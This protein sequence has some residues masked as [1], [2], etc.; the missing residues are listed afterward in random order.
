MQA[1]G[2]WTKILKKTFP[3]LNS[4]LKYNENMGGVD[5]MDRMLALYPH[6]GYKTKWTI[7]VILHFLMIAN[8]NNWFERDKRTIF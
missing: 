2:E 4:V 7:R 1:V 8:V 3:Q 6:W 5:L